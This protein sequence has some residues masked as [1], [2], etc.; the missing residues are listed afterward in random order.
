[1]RTVLIVLSFVIGLAIFGICDVE[2]EL[3]SAASAGSATIIIL[4]LISVSLI[5]TER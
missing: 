4:M 3:S 5:L 2:L 1:M